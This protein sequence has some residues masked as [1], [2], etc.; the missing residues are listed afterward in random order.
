MNENDE[1]IYDSVVAD[2]EWDP[3][4]IRPPFNL[5]AVLAQSYAKWAPSHL[6]QKENSFA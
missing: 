1:P 2:E 3:E 5:E 4:T 6:P